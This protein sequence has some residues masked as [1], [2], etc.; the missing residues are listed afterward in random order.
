[1]EP[2]YP[3]WQKP[4]KTPTKNCEKIAADLGNE[5]AVEIF[6]KKITQEVLHL[7]QVEMLRYA[8]AT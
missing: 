4:T 6:G 5:T 8:K 2:Q 1:M 3:G 7:I